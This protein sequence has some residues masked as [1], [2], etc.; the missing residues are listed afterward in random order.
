MEE[1]FSSQYMPHG[2]CYLWKPEILWLNVLSDLVI[3]SAYFSIP[4]ALYYFAHKRQDLTLRPIFIL[5]SLFI[6]LCG[7]THLLN[8]TVVW[9][10]TYGVHALSKFAT[11]IISGI[12]A[13]SLYRALPYALSLP[14]HTTLQQALDKI[15]LEKFH[16]FEI[17]STEK[18]MKSQMIFQ[19]ITSSANEGLWEYNFE[20][21]SMWLSSRVFELLGFDKGEQSETIDNFLSLVPL[22]QRDDLKNYFF[23]PISPEDNQTFEFQIKVKNGAHRWLATRAVNTLD[24]NGRHNYR[25]G[26]VFDIHERKVLQQQLAKQDQKMRTLIDQIPI[27]IHVY[28]SNGV[29][30]TFTESNS[31]ADKILR[32]DQDKQPAFPLT[33]A[34]PEAEALEASNLLKQA[35]IN[36]ITSKREVITYKNNQIEKVF[37]TV[38]F[39]PSPGDAAA[40]FQDITEQRCAQQNLNQALRKLQLILQGSNDGFWHWLDPTNDITEW[41]DSLFQMLS[42]EP[43]EFVPSFERFY[44]MIY[45]KDV[46]HVKRN[47]KIAMASKISF[48]IE[49]RIAHKHGEYRWYRCRGTPY[50]S[51]T[52]E[53]LEV[54]GS[55]SDIH[56]TKALQRDLVRSNK[57]LEQFSLIASHDLKE[58]L[59]TI[60]TFVH[61]LLSD[62]Q[63]GNTKRQTEDAAYIVGACT[64]MS[65]LIDSLLLLSQAGA[66]DL[67]FESCNIGD[68][69]G[70]VTDRLQTKIEETQAK[71][72]IDENLP[73]VVVDRVQLELVFQNLIQNAIKFCKHDTPPI[74]H[75]T[76]QKSV[77]KDYTDIL[78]RDMGIGIPENKLTDIFGAFK[79]IHSIETYPGTGIGLAIVVKIL[80]KFKARIRVESQEDEETTFFLTLPITKGI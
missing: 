56:R 19:R 61:H 4:V 24:R 9:H 45:P 75:I 52:G 62:I 70:E 29:D 13:I 16:Q 68:I 54:T 30:I 10:G 79:K 48:D 5:F 72:T 51:K 2:H 57:E 43:Q 1:F 28:K 8:I 49:F 20:T 21:C 39:Q 22:K 35:A 80:K 44:S 27:G 69:L 55:L 63:S 50:Y 41:S 12:T 73:N 25:S 47:F 60:R 66:S 32:T 18:L 38:Y 23:S 74:I 76:S 11:A 59:R 71:I 26:T 77:N 7:V 34:F 33:E 58:P 40:L 42:F 65:N 53:L 14:S 15:S 17:E 46:A 3:A 64:R 78:I 6:A 36:G 31:A 67:Q 37:S